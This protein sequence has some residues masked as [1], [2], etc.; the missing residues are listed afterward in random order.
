MQ[1]KSISP[2]NPGQRAASWRRWAVLLVP[3][4]ALFVLGS[5][6]NNSARVAPPTTPEHGLQAV[7]PDVTFG[8]IADAD[9]DVGPGAAESMVAQHPAASR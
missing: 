8:H 1:A 7:V 4:A 3:L 2:S 9:R 6:T 5:A